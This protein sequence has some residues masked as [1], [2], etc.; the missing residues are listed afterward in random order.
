MA[1]F[2]LLSVF[3]N[4]AFASN[5]TSEVVTTMISPYVFVTALILMAYRKRWLEGSWKRW[6]K[7]LALSIVLT[8]VGL[9]IGFM[10]IVL[11]LAKLR[12]GGSC[13]SNTDAESAVLFTTPLLF[14]AGQ[15]SLL[16]VRATRQ[17]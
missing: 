13:F 1:A 5:S 15:L 12:N 17:A 9:G 6:W 2:A 3:A 10:A 8:G 4:V 14:I 7:Q 16:K 11:I